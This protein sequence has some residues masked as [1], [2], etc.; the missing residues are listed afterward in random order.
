MDFSR[1]KK[2]AGLY[3]PQNEHDSCGVGFIASIKGEKTHQIVLDGLKILE[4]LEHR[5]A[6]GADP[7]MGDGAGIMLQIP[8]KF[9]REKVSLD[10]VNLPSEGEYGIGMVFLPKEQGARLACERAIE[11]AIIEE[12]QVLLGWRTVPVNSTIPMSPRVKEKEPVIRQVFIGRGSDIFVQDAFERKLMVIRKI[13]SH[14]INKLDLKHGREFYFCSLSS[15]VVLYK[16]LLLSNQVGAYF[17]D[18]TDKD[19]KSAL[20]LVHQRFSTNTFPEWSLA[21]PF[22]LIAHNGEIN[23]VKGNFNWLKAR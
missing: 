9:F 20:A 11:R 19:V 3:N 18:L 2:T 7:L 5:G 15:R 16:G 8:D 4:N 21:Q 6:V 10:G 22:R 13:A 14:D 12:G 23:T 17:Y 1:Q